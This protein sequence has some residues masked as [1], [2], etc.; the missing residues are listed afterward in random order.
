MRYTILDSDRSDAY[1]RAVAATAVGITLAFF[2]IPGLIAGAVAG[3]IIAG[4]SSIILSDFIATLVG[5][6]VH[7]SI[8]IFVLNIAFDHIVYTWYGY[9]D[10]IVDAITTV[11]SAAITFVGSWLWSAAEVV[12]IA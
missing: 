7:Y 3:A 12:G 11:T 6:A 4:I 1:H 5:L 9:A 8:G 2:V 10:C